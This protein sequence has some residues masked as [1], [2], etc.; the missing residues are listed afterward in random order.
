MDEFDAKHSDL[1]SENAALQLQIQKL[2]DELGKRDA[3]GNRAEELAVQ[4]RRLE[5]EKKALVA[6]LEVLK[7]KVR[8]I[9]KILRGE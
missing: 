9:E 1:S 4:V 3:S 7:R 6:E 2:K 8:G 5:D